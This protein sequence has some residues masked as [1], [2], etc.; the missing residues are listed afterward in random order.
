[1]SLTVLI[2]ANEMS[3]SENIGLRAVYPLAGRTLLERQA[4]RALEIGATRFL[5]LVETLPQ[6]LTAAMDR[7]A[8][9]HVPIVPV[10]NAAEIVAHMK[11]DDQLLLIADALHAP[12]SCYQALSDATAPAVLA[13]P[14]N[15][16]ARDFERI[17]GQTRWA[18]L[19]LIPNHIVH[20]LSDIADDWDIGSTLLRQT[21]QAGATRIMCEPV[22]F[23]R[24]EIA[25][26]AEPEDAALV[27]GQMLQQAEFS[28]EGM[29]QQ[30]LFAPLAR[31]IGPALLPKNIPTTAFFGSSIALLVGG[32]VAACLSEPLWA[33]ITALFASLCYALGSFQQHF[34]D[35]SVISLK[36]RKAAEWLAYIF[37]LALVAP[38]LTHWPWSLE[39]VGFAA[40]ALVLM[41]LWS[42]CRKLF[43]LNNIESA[44]FGMALPDP[45]I[46]FVILGISALF[47]GSM[48]ALP[49]AA[50]LATAG[51]LLWLSDISQ[52]EAVHHKK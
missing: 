51:I 45:E 16:A 37:P 23:E 44:R 52:C 33:A 36:L 11:A 26:V 41:L 49:F 47:G 15:Q 12:T 2:I 46:F 7:I 29:G 13:T 17:D 24:G 34:S 35:I 43:D 1:M 22:M 6:S 40:L 20:Q 30:A 28:G 21:I 32:L 3:E 31:L 9:K 10:R 27:T 5:I 42:V 39:S 18:G 19:A 50:I 48:L 4:E 8:T 38:S 14:D 25:I